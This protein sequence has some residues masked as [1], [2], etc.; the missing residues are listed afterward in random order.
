MD[1]ISIIIPVY[2]VE[3]YLSECIDSVL[4]QTYEKF[5]LILVDDGSSD[6]S[7]KVCD[8]YEEKDNR[9]RVIH[10]ENGGVSS[11][12]NVGLDNSKG[13]YITFIDSDDT[14][15]S[16]YLELMHND[17]V[18]KKSDACYCR[19]CLFDD[20]SKIKVNS[21]LPKESNLSGKRKEKFL[22]KFFRGK[23]G[24]SSCKILYSKSVL[25][26]V[27]FDER[28]RFN[29]D[30]LFTLNAVLKCKS[31]SSIDKVLYNYRKNPSSATKKY[32]SNFLQNYQ[33]LY[34][35]LKNEAD[36]KAITKKCL[37]VYACRAA[38]FLINNEIKHRNHD[39]DK[40]I[41]EIKASVFYNKFKPKYIFASFPR[42]LSKLKVFVFWLKVKINL[43]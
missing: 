12:R 28:I 33:Y 5:E 27:R 11:A 41:E 29:E 18:A 9:V 40:K 6:N 16:Q 37:D 43:I 38:Y 39:F 13:E 19:L 17:I 3:K 25:E 34:E 35:I 36:G 31:I 1:L 15:D 32:I 24:Y 20:D 22:R 30:F 10:K 21:F 23:Y 7:G 4:C 14:V 42:T 2:N 26:N 8:E